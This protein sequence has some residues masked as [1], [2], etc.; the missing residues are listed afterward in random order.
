A[1]ID[2]LHQQF[3]NV[4]ELGM[5]V[6]EFMEGAKR[7]TGSIL[8]DITPVTNTPYIPPTPEV[9]LPLWLLAR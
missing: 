1:V 5:D 3:P 8:S 6:D 7:K 9:G 2:E 4:P